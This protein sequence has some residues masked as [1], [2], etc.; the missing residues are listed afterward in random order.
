M[1]L[2]LRWGGRIAESDEMAAYSQMIMH[3]SF[4]KSIERASLLGCGLLLFS[5]LCLCHCASAIPDFFGRNT[6]IVFL[7]ATLVAVISFCFVSWLFKASL[8]KKPIS[9]HFFIGVAAIGSVCSLIGVFAYVWIAALMP[10]WITINTAGF[11]FG[12]GVCCLYY[13][14]AIIYQEQTSRTRM[15]ASVLSCS[16]SVAL[17]FA[18]SFMAEPLQILVSVAALVLSAFFL[19][20]ARS[21]CL[22]NGAVQVVIAKGG[23]QEPLGGLVGRFWKPIAGGFLCAFVAGL[24]WDP[25]LA[26]TA[27]DISLTRISMFC[28]GILLAFFAGVRE[29]P[30]KKPISIMSLDSVYMPVCVAVMLV[31]PSIEAAPIPGW[32]VVTGVLHEVCSVAM[33]LIMWLSCLDKAELDSKHSKTIVLL[34]ACVL[35]LGLLSGILLIPIMGTTGRNLSL[36]AFAAYLT[37]AVCSVAQSFG[38][39]SQKGNAGIDTD[40]RMGGEVDSDGSFRSHCRNMAEEAGLSPREKDVFFYLVRGHSQAYI[41]EE[42]LV[43]ENTVRTHVRSIYRK[44]GVSSKED[45]L[46]A[47]SA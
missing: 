24:V 25:L 30:G 38:G 41:A 9:S 27:F 15:L 6:H 16:F 29:L 7:T 34:P 21:A 44:V 23:K 4:D 17:F 37:A 28:A 3:N 39:K 8:S 20:V 11:L 35:S 45:L 43:S 5:V 12:W 26:Q 13:G 10:A 36:V 2:Q 31:L 18:V 46:K 32:E 19:I 33:L 22:Q 40:K 47:V 14:W 42:L 1:N